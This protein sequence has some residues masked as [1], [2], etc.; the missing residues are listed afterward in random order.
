DEVVEKEAIKAEYAIKH[1]RTRNK[2]E[3][4]KELVEQEEREQKYQKFLENNPWLFGHEYVQRLDIRELTRGD[5]VDFCMESVDG[6]YDIIEIKTPSK[7]VLVEDS[8]HDTHK[9]SSE[10]SGAIAQV[11]D[12]IHSIEMN[13]AQINLED[14]IHMLKPRGIIVIGDGL[15]DKKRNSLRILN[16]HLN[17]ITV[18]TFSD[19]TEFGTR[20]VRRYEGD[21]EIPTKSITDNN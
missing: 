16:S 13:E 17:G 3:E 15:S 7:T 18:Y 8:S 14:G 10:L 20:M 2:L 1:A 19:L 21:A 6:Y 4:Y 9:A 5:E 12:Y 11:E